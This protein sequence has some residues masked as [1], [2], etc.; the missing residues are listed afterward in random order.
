MSILSARVQKAKDD[1]ET[2]IISA[3]DSL[4]RGQLPS[5]YSAI[6]T[7]T[8]KPA[9]IQ[10]PH[11]QDSIRNESGQSIAVYQKAIDKWVLANGISPDKIPAI[12]QKETISHEQF[13]YMSIHAQYVAYVKPG[14]AFIEAQMNARNGFGD[15]KLSDEAY[16]AGQI[17]ATAQSAHKKLPKEIKD[18]LEKNSEPWNHK[19]LQNIA[20]STGTYASKF[21]QDGNVR[22]S[23]ADVMSLIFKNSHR[24]PELENGFN[25]RNVSNLQH[26][27]SNKFD[28]R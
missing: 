17:R 1:R 3:K 26:E 23:T 18:V 5:G 19:D 21:R 7:D 15:D 20:M 6:E 14:P 9:N 8:R 27:S 24:M 10:K 2:S 28:E 4:S 11:D 12:G 13:N 25:E 16:F 22:I